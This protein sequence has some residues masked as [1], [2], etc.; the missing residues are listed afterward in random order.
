MKLDKGK[1]FKKKNNFYSKEDNESSSDEE[2][3][4][5]YVEEFMFIDVKQPSR[6]RKKELFE[7]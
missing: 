6:Q 2:R 3:G 5:I 4:D 7:E 1:F